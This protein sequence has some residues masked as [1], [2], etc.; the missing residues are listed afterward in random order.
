M[1]ATGRITADDLA[2]GV[3]LSEFPRRVAAEVCPRPSRV[4]DETT[5]A[6]ASVVS[7]ASTS[8]A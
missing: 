6:Q 4:S 8:G 3:T 2:G 7:R 5:L 1:I